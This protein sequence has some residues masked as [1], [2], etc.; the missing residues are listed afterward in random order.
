MHASKSLCMLGAVQG[1]SQCIADGALQ[2]GP[3]DAALVAAVMQTARSNV[4]DPRVKDHSMRSF[5]L[6]IG[7]GPPGR[8]VAYSR[9]A[10]EAVWCRLESEILLGIRQESQHEALDSDQYERPLP[11]NIRAHVVNE[12]RERADHVFELSGTVFDLS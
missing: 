11:Q 5:A 9:E 7:D 4:E 1:N 12:G 6:L 10:T 8:D 3:E 2:A